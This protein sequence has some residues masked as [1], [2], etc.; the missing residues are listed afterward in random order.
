MLTRTISG[1]VF[2]AIIA[3]FFCLR[4]FVWTDTFL[5]L[6][7]FLCTVGT[8]EVA[9]AVKE[10][11][12]KTIF[13]LQI[14]YGTLFVPLYYLIK[15][16]L[17][18][19]T[20][21]I[22]CISFALLITLI[23]LIVYRFTVKENNLRK[24]FFFIVLPIYYPSFLILSSLFLNGLA[25]GYIGLL[26]VFVVSPLSD[27]F[28]YLVGMTYQKIRKGNAKKLCPK[29][30]PKKTVAGAIGG[31]LGGIL[32]ALIIFLIYNVK[33]K[34]MPAIVLFLLIG[35]LGAVAT[36]VGDLFESLIKRKMGIKDMGK[37]M[38]GHGGVMDR[39]DGITFCSVVVTILLFFIR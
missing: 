34:C 14:I 19:K 22:V 35:L 20:A 3:G 11:T 1:A 13:I 9:R 31:I 6:L 18:V 39:I 5:I 16:L 25:T 38:P 17:H 21:L 26:C 7:L 30:S 37:I 2:V 24:D 33:I 15:I 29:L 10:K 8:F 27:T 23:T 36:E 4:Q 12:N 28:A 32:G